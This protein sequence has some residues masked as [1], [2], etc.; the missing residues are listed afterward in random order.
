M[1][2]EVKKAAL[3]TTQDLQTFRENWQSDETQDLLAKSRES[4]QRDG[5]LAKAN[6]VAKYGWAK[7]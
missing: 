5:N 6:K 1:F 7:P 3:Q 2:A 4:L